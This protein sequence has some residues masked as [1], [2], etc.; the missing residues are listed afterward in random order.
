MPET[1]AMTNQRVR[2]SFVSGH[3]ASTGLVAFLAN[4]V[5]S[6]AGMAGGG[7]ESSNRAIRAVVFDRAGHPAIRGVLAERGASPSVCVAG[8]SGLVAVFA[9]MGDSSGAES[10]LCVSRSGDGGRTWSKAEPIE[11]RGLSADAGR[12]RDPA[13]AAVSGG[14]IRL[15][16]VS[17]EGASAVIRSAISSDGGRYEVEA[18]LRWT[19]DVA[20]LADPVVVKSGRGV[21]L[22]A[23]RT[24][25]PDVRIRAESV[26]GLRFE[27]RGEVSLSNESAARGSKSRARHIAYV[28]ERGSIRSIASADG[29]DWIAGA[30][31]PLGRVHD[32]SIAWMEDG[33]IIALVCVDRGAS[34]VKLL[35]PRGE[36][37]GSRSPG[38]SAGA[39]SDVPA[40]ADAGA[41]VVAPLHAEAV[42]R[43]MNWARNASAPDPTA[44]LTRNTLFIEPHGVPNWFG[45]W[46]D[47]GPPMDFLVPPPDFENPVD[48]GAW[49]ESWSRAGKSD[50]AAPLYRSLLTRFND[51]GEPESALPAFSSLLNDANPSIE[52]GPWEPAAHPEWERS[53]QESLPLVEQFTAATL[54]RDYATPIN[55]LP[56]DSDRLLIGII[57]PDLAGHRTMAKQILSN[58]WRAEGGKVRGEAMVESWATVLRGARHLEQGVSLIEQLVGVSE[59]NL[60]YSQARIALA[61]GVLSPA[62]IQ[63]AR[64]VLGELETAAPDPSRWVQGELAFAMDIVQHS[65]VAVDPAGRRAFDG[66]R[67]RKVLTMGTDDEV[68]DEK[69]QSF[70]KADPVETVVAF[71]NY[72]REYAELARTGYPAVRAADLNQLGLHY[73]STN[74]VTTALMPGLGRTHALRYRQ[75]ASRRAT[76]LAL[77]IHAHRLRTGAWPSRLDDLPADEI[78]SAR[79]DPFSG[80]DFGYHVTESGPVLYSVSENGTDD[81]GVHSAR[82]GDDA[83]GTAASDDYVFWPPQDAVRR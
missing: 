77:S 50:D 19:H 66:E 37:R 35:V 9:R 68:P 2:W 82:W 80:R 73:A 7:A 23:R 63:H 10:D 71:Q 53:Y 8:E 1:D 22:F 48:Y 36:S 25:R 16:F 61:K 14:R 49:L 83:T 40:D 24:D 39:D 62:D 15:Y 52:I 51:K 28:V 45:Q 6:S 65:A 34:A 13:L 64:R 12:P 75:E 38:G 47:E 4:L 81:G 79:E 55:F 57:L 29:S 43:W 67:M 31:L 70:L 76:N 26:D 72:Y 33:S 60:V 42:E 44:E 74:A 27:S 41:E 20:G 69:L 11:F 5:L 46:S 54:H 78:G 32:A 56:Q 18:G 17:G 59:K 21:Q 30:S 58:G 3:A